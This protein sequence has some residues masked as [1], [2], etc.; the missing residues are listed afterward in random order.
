MNEKKSKKECVAYHKKSCVLLSKL[1]I[2]EEIF[3][4]WKKK[5]ILNKKKDLIKRIK[6]GWDA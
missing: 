4:V 1:F 5:Y 6:F 2:P 3:F